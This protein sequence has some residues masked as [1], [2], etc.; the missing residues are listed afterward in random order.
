MIKTDGSQEAEPRAPGMNG[1]EQRKTFRAESR[2]GVTRRM[3]VM[4]KKL[5]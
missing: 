3:E 5:I 4:R 1:V 2:C